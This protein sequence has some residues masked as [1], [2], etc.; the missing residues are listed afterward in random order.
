[1]NAATRF[2]SGSS[3]SAPSGGEL[4]EVGGCIAVLSEGPQERGESG[5]RAAEEHAHAALTDA[6]DLGDLAV[7]VT[8]DVI[9][10]R[11]ARRG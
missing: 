1:M 5:P 6:E 2:S 7:I 8:L 10:R 3:A 9:Q 4:G 11:V